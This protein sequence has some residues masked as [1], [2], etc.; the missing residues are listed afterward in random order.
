MEPIYLKLYVQQLRKTNFEYFLWEG[1][2][3]L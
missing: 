3:V 1:G 2:L